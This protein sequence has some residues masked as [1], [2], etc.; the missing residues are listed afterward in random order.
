MTAGLFLDRGLLEPRAAIDHLT[1]LA[2]I[3]EP[4]YP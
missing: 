4:H 2:L 3:F 1:T